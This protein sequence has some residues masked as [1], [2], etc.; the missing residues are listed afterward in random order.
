M[1]LLPELGKKGSAGALR[2]VGNGWLG[3]RA[4][5]A[6]G[7]VAGA[8]NLAR[9]QVGERTWG[10]RASSPASSCEQRK[11]RLQVWDG[12]Q[13]WMRTP[14]TRPSLGDINQASSC[15]PAM[16]MATWGSRGAGQGRG[17]LF[18]KGKY[19]SVFLS[20]SS[21]FTKLLFILFKNSEIYQN[22]KCATQNLLQHSF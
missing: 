14:S 7:G 10:S 3:A 5:K 12:G 11:R 17:A 9:E 15:V 20:P 4:A 2:E 18:P 6:Q 13:D 21:L 22:K 16:P 8:L 19:G 1:V